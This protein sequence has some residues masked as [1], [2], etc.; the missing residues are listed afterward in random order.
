MADL[1]RVEGLAE[2]ARKLKRLDAQLP[3]ALRLALNQAA[4]V[5]VETA[6]PQVPTRSGRAR[7]SIR[8]RSTRTLA[9]VSAGGDQAPY[10]AWL[11][12]GGRVGPDRSIERPFFKE[13]R[14][15]YGAYFA[16]KRSGEF[17]TILRKSLLQVARAAGFEVD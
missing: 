2:F 16:K 4:D 3:K 15:L 10:Y 14:Y 17:P 12:F 6:Q 8:S 13:G 7:A 11:D 9:R 1:I 5:I